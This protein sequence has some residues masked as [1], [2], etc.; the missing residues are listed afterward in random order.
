[1][2]ESKIMALQCAAQA[3][4][5]TRI[6][7]QGFQVQEEEAIDRTGDVAKQEQHETNA[8]LLDDAAFF[9]EEAVK[10]LREIPEVAE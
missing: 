9:L 8:S 6:M 4:N 7:L 5:A 1:M 3:I 10:N 2:T